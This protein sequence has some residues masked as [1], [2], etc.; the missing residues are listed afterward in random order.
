LD[1]LPLLLTG[2]LPAAALLT[3][4]ATL[5]L[6]VLI[7]IGHQLTPRFAQRITLRSVGT[8][9]LGTQVTVPC[10]PRWNSTGAELPDGDNKEIRADQKCQ[11]RWEWLY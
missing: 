7:L 9:L 5:L 2:L 8:F 3:T 10:R 4:L 11:P 1:G 6:F